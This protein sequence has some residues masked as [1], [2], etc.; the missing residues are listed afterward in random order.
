MFLFAVKQAFSQPAM[1]LISLDRT[2]QYDSVHAQHCLQEFRSQIMWRYT[3]S[4]TAKLRFRR[5]H[6]GQETVL[7]CFR[8]FVDQRLPRDSYRVVLM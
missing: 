6:G 2:K 7:S 4:N 5:L 3:V 8:D 1:L